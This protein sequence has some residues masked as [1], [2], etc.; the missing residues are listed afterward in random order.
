MRSEWHVIQTF[1]LI[2]I[3]WIVLQVSIGAGSVW[4]GGAIF[5]GGDKAKLVYKY[6]R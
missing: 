1:G 6:H 3:I 5:G 2:A 4:F